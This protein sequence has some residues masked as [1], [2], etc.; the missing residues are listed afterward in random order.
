MGESLNPVEATSGYDS[1]FATLHERLDFTGLG[2]F[3]ELEVE[4]QIASEGWKVSEWSECCAVS[5]SNATGKC[6]GT[7][8]G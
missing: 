6:R 8:T 1:E 2:D 4:G 5:D 7:V 3:T